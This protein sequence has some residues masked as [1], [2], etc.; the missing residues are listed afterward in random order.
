MI[1]I[2]KG[3]FYGGYEPHD[4]PGAYIVT[5]HEV[6]DSTGQTPSERI[7]W[8]G[9]GEW[10]ESRDGVP[11]GYKALWLGTRQATR[12]FVVFVRD[13]PTKESAQYDA[14]YRKGWKAKRRPAVP[15][16]ATEPM[17]EGLQQGWKDSP[18]NP[19][20]GQWRKLNLN[21]RRKPTARANPASMSVEAAET[22]IQQLGGMGKLRAMVGASDFVR[23]S[24]NGYPALT[25]RFKGSRSLNVVTITLDPSDTYSLAFGRIVKYDVKPG[26]TFS[27]VYAE[28]LRPTFERAT[29]LYLSLRNNPRSTKKRGGA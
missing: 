1:T 3:V 7:S 10:I 21:P 16:T 24:R 18:N 12:P 28:Q 26:P 14:A 5:Q 9:P 22:L 20:P 23:T 4:M 25:F 19:T 27:D 6:K 8:N 13:A 15:S 29:G 2:S 17:V 11:K